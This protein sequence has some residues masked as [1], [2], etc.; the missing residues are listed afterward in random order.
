M[1]KNSSWELLPENATPAFPARLC[2]TSEGRQNFPDIIQ[3]AYGEKCLTGFNRYG[4][5]LG[6]VIPREA[7]MILAEND[8]TVD[9]TTRLRIKNAARNLL[10][11]QEGLR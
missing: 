5:F 7:L 11:G 8:A 9:D 1:A 3:D 10:R 6:A 2:T 4:R